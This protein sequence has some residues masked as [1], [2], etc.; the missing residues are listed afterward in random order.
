MY[1]FIVIFLFIFI[2]GCSTQINTY[3]LEGYKKQC[4]NEIDYIEVVSF[5]G[6]IPTHDVICKDGTKHRV[7][8]RYIT[9][10]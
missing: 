7:Y 6:L 1:K 2:T 5:F 4:K 3:E 8:T 10:N 9:N